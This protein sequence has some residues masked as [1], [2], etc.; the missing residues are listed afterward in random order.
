M[1]NCCTTPRTLLLTIAIIAISCGARGSGQGHLIPTGAGSDKD[2]RLQ[3]V[4][5]LDV[6]GVSLRELCDQFSDKAL[7]L[8]VG[9]ETSALRLQIVLKNRPLLT[10]MKAIADLAP[11]TWEPVA[12][13]HGYVFHMSE[14]AVKRRSTWWKIY[15]SERDAAIAAQRRFVLA[16]LN[17]DHGKVD[18]SAVQPQIAPLI[19]AKDKFYNGLP[20]ELKQRIADHLM[21]SLLYQIWP[22]AQI[23]DGSMNEGATTVHASD[24]PTDVQGFLRTWFNRGPKSIDP[25]AENATLVF[26]NEGITITMGVIHPGGKEA[27][28]TMNFGV[29]RCLE[30][31]TV[32][33]DQDRVV[34]AVEQLKKNVPTNWKRL[35]QYRKSTVWPGDAAFALQQAQPAVHPKGLG[36][37][38][39]ADRLKWLKDNAP[40]EFVSDYYDHPCVPLTDQQR[41][42]KLGVSLSK[43][44][45]ALASEQDLSW[46][47]SENDVY[48]F[49]NNRWYRDDALQVPPHIIKPWLQMLATARIPRTGLN[50]VSVNDHERKVRMDLEAR[51]VTTLSPYQIAGGL[52]WYSEVGKDGESSGG[53]VF[54]FLGL[55]NRLF[56]ERYTALFYGGLNE[57]ARLAIIAG[58][59]RFS[60]LSA[61]QA[62]QA[63]FLR[64]SLSEVKPD[65]GVYL[66]IK[67]KA[68][69]AISIVPGKSN[70]DGIELTLTNEPGRPGE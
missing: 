42:R 56:H 53:R 22:S 65:Q 46:K 48:L 3:R 41:E 9:S 12:K 45:N 14:E 13:G 27:L 40:I 38:R 26:V 33:M 69:G 44:L 11:G 47:Q 24:L 50:H 39:L 17:A 31:I 16:A 61:E 52:A 30:M 66:V 59:L 55:T 18:V 36:P 2:S 60:D 1:M 6:E 28:S 5:S 35:A 68:R 32:P 51:I 19:T 37:P 49:R 54:P 10:L 57:E 70:V 23:S 7:E 8:S 15:L 21:D 25:V 43:E 34:R 62:A 58:K 64:P 29:G 67:P 63:I 20:S 4:I